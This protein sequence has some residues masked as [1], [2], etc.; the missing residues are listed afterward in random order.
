LVCL[1]LHLDFLTCLLADPSSYK[2]LSP[3]RALLYIWFC[4]MVACCCHTVNNNI[5]FMVFAVEMFLT[6]CPTKNA[7]K[8]IQT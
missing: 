3:P 7:D 2:W 8:F 4:L 5:Q 6:C 1:P